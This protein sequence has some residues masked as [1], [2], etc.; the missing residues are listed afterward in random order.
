MY[1][2]RGIQVSA[3]ETRTSQLDRKGTPR[4]RHSE[5]FIAFKSA[6]MEFINAEKSAISDVHKK[7]YDDLNNIA[8]CEV[9]LLAGS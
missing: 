4:G 1:P 7:D 3:A 8:E 9:R 6:K 5:S 2:E